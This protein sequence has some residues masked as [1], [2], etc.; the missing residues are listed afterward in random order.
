MVEYGW[1]GQVIDDSTWKPFERK[2]GPSLWG[3]DRNWM[4]PEKREEARAAL[5]R[6][7]RSGPAP[8]GA[9][10]RRQLQPHARR[11]PLVGS[12]EG[13]EG[14]LMRVRRA[15]GVSMKAGVASPNGVVIQDVPAAEA[16]TDRHPGQDQGHRAQPRRPRL[17]AR[18]T[19]AT[20]P[21]PASRSAANSPAR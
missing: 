6:V 14:G 7:R 20:A 11:L 12:D 2:H 18:A 19:P 4:S 8:A 16:E 9:G 5:H 15:E 21:R 10:D 1:G 13:A 3:H 17:G